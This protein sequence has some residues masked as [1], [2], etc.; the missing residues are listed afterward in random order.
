MNYIIYKAASIAGE[1]NLLNIITYAS[2]LLPFPHF[3]LFARQSCRKRRKL[4]DNLL[5]PIGRVLDI[6]AVMKSG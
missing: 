5:M 6:A 4:H 1:P 2:H 3:R